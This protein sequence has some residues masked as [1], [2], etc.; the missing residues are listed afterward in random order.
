MSKIDETLEYPVAYRGAQ[1]YLNYPSK[2]VEHYNRE[3]GFRWSENVQTS[4]KPYL[5]VSGHRLSCLTK[6][7]SMSGVKEAIDFQIKCMKAAPETYCRIRQPLDEF[8]EE[9]KNIPDAPGEVS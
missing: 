7:C 3:S 8:L 5:T 2:R 4:D 1:I 9:L 6:Y